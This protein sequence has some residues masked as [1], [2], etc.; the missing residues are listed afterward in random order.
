M[1]ADRIAG[2]QL[3]SCTVRRTDD[4]RK[5]FVFDPLQHVGGTYLHTLII[6]RV[7]S[8]LESNHK[9]VKK[10]RVELINS[11][12]MYYASNADYDDGSSWYSRLQMHDPLQRIIFL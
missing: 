8:V 3:Y 6:V 11:I 7:P 2:V 4:T 1:E 5:A 10:L 12:L 9:I